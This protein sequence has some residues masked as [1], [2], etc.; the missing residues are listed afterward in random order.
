MNWPSFGLSSFEP[1]LQ[2]FCGTRVG[3]INLLR[4]QRTT[5]AVPRLADVL[6]RLSNEEASA[7]LELEGEDSTLRC[8]ATVSRLL[9]LMSK[10]ENSF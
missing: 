1:A 7:T 9:R 5:P 10:L 8:M 3:V 4:L 2:D 6:S